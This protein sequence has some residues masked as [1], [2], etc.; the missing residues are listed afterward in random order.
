MKRLSLILAL[1]LGFAAGANA[2][3]VY[4]N[5]SNSARWGV[6]LSYELACP[7]DVKYDDVLK[8]DLLG[9]G[10]GVSFGVAYNIPVIYNFY[11]EPGVTMAYNTYS[12]NKA[13]IDKFFDSDPS[14]AGMRAKAASVRFWEIRVPIIGG[15][16]FDVLDNLGISVFTG[17]ELSLALSGKTHVKVG[18]LTATEGVYGDDGLLNRPDVKW[19]F[20]VGAT[21]ND[22]FYGAISG[23]VGLCDMA[24][25]KERMHSNLFDMTVG[26]NF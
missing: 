11:F 16:R 9:N 3:S 4:N 10:S 17:P 1:L 2:R 19:R 15:Y 18:S 21:I 26:Y 24:K 8:A 20:G 23:A 6:R 12:I 13:A 7:G 22:H 25:G 5:P 14:L